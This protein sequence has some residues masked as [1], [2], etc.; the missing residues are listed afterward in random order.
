V[1]S[2]VDEIPSASQ[3][4]LGARQE[5]VV[6][7]VRNTNGVHH[8]CTVQKSSWKPIQGEKPMKCEQ[9]NQHHKRKRDNGR[10]APTCQDDGSP[11]GRASELGG[12]AACLNRFHQ[13]GNKT[14]ILRC[15]SMVT[16]CC[17]WRQCLA[18]LCVCVCVCVCACVRACTCVCVCVCVCVRARARVCVYV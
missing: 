10:G 6:D 13:R 16:R 11:T 3:N 14:L 12:R 2:E 15:V 7:R 5:S 1:S 18:L 9:L 17:R 4:T 8:Q